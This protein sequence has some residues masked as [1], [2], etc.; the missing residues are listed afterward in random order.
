[1]MNVTTKEPSIAPRFKEI[2]PFEYETIGEQVAFLGKVPAVV[3]F[4]PFVT[5]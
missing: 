3:A 5:Q 1:M 4:T 2:T